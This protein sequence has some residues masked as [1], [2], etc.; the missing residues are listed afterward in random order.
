VITR[1][2]LLSEAK[3]YDRC[4]STLRPEPSARFH[5]PHAIAKKACVA[6]ST[7]RRFS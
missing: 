3:A 5:A 2:R 6:A 1:S 4:K 7:E